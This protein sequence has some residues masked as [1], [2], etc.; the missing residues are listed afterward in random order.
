VGL[1]PK[2]VEDEPIADRS[3]TSIP[4]RV[5]TAATVVSLRYVR[6]IASV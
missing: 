2:A 6:A 1:R 5:E 4:K 3:S